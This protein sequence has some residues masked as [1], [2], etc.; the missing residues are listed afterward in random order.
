MPFPAGPYAVVGCAHQ[1]RVHISDHGSKCFVASSRHETLISS[2]FRNRVRKKEK[3]INNRSERQQ[4][5]KKKEK[6]SYSHLQFY[7]SRSE[8]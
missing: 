7:Y 2:L 8:R 3:E 1:G 5:K 4:T 6:I